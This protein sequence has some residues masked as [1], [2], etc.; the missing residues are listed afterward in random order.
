MVRLTIIVFVVPKTGIYG[1]LLGL[2]VSQLVSTLFDALLVRK[3]CKAFPPVSE[4]LVLPAVFAFLP[5]QLFVML[6]RLLQKETQLP[7]LLLLLLSCGIYCV[8]YILLLFFGKIIRKE[9]WKE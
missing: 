5:A 2:L 1:V 7:S 3:Y 9:D 6:Y 4:W 8:S